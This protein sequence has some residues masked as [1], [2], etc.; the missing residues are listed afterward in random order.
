MTSKASKVVAYIV[1]LIMIVSI[2]MMTVYA[3][4]YDCKSDIH[5]YQTI[6]VDPSETT[7]GSI[8]YTCA[9]C[10]NEHVEI[11]PMNGHQWT[12]CV[13]VKEATCIKDGYDHRNCINN[14]EHIETRS[15]M[16][17]G[18][19]DFIETIVDATCE[20]EGLITGTC[21]MCG[22]PYFQ[23]IPKLEHMYSGWIIDSEPSAGVEGKKH[24]ICQHDAPHIIR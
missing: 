11:I 20:Q 1:A 22:E 5:D 13:I 10:G 8:T 4:T 23:T 16:P 7:N 6:I 21:T 2:S 19:H 3:T 24:R 12:E 14:S 17:T 9:L 18:I 15:I